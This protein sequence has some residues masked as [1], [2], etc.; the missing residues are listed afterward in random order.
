MFFEPR[1]REQLRARQQLERALRRAVDENGLELRPA[2]RHA[3][4][5]GRVVA[6]EAGIVWRHPSRGRVSVEEDLLFAERK[7][8]GAAIAAR[9]I[10]RTTAFLGEL[11]HEI[12]GA[13]VCVA[14]S[15]SQL[16][17]PATADGLLAGIAAAGVEGDRLQVELLTG[18]SWS[19]DDEAFEAALVRLA[20][21]GVNIALREFGADRVAFRELRQLPLDGLILAED[22]VRD[23][24]RH[25]QAEAFAEALAGLGRRL[26]KRVV[27]RGVETET[28]LDLLR[29][30]GCE[31]VG[32]PLFEPRTLLTAS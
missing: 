4:E 21:H 29:Q 17:D 9:T 14:F 18:G 27:A 8:L 7:G 31:E 20:D 25:D 28:Q 1:M 6:V 16:A 2:P 5:D 32:G 13:R 22:L 30:A 11:G 10:E 19:L 15:P 24:G 23:L 26:G 12:T 3:V